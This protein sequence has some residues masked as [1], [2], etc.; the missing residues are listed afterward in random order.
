MHRVG[1]EGW[2]AH[3]D[4]FGAIRSRRAVADPFAGRC[5]D[6]LTGVDLE[7]PGASFHPQDAR[8]HNGVF[9]EIRRLGRLLPATRTFHPGDTE[10]VRAGVDAADELLDPLRL[11]A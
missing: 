4:V 6:G 1:R 3:G 10:R 8:Q 11:V 5:V 9:V 2:Y 7:R